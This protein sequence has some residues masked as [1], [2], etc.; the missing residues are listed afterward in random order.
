MRNSFIAILVAAACGGCSGANSSGGGSEAQPRTR[1]EALAKISDENRHNFELWKQQVI[2]ACDATQAFG[3][4]SSPS[5]ESQGVDGVA[6]LQHN[7]NSLVFN[8]GGSFAIISGTRSLSGIA[9]SKVQQSITINGQSQSIAVEAKREGSHCTVFLFGQNV[10]ET[11]IAERAYIGAQWSGQTVPPTT[12]QA[13]Q[14]NLLGS[15]QLAEV[16]QPGLTNLILQTLAMPSEDVQAL[17]TRKLGLQNDQVK[18]FELAPQALHLAVKLS[19]DSNAIWSLPSR[20]IANARVLKAI[21]ST[22]DIALEMRLA[23]PHLEF[24]GASNTADV[25]SLKYALNLTLS[26]KDGLYSYTMRSLAAQGLVPFNDNEATSC[27]RDRA[28]AYLGRARSQYQISPSVD[29]MFAPCQVLAEDFMA[30]A[31][32]TGLL[33]SLIPLVFAGVT[34]SPRA[35]YNQ[36]DQILR[37]LAQATLKSGRDPRAELDPNGQ[38]QIVGVLADYISQLQ[39]ELDHTTYISHLSSVGDLAYTWSFMGQQVSVGR[40]QTILQSLDSASELFIYSTQ[41]VLRSLA[42]NPASSDEALSFAATNINDAYKNEARKALAVAQALSYDDFEN[43]TLSHVIQNRTSLDDLKQWSTQ[44]SAVQTALR[45][46]KN[47]RAV[48]NILVGASVRWLQTGQTKTQDLSAIYGALDNVSVPFTD[49]AKTLLQA[50]TTSLA[51]GQASL[52]FAQS[53]TSEYKQ[54]AIEI[55][56]DAKALDHDQWGQTFFNM[57]LQNRPTT[58]KVRAWHEF[59]SA[60]QAFTARETARTQGEF[61]STTDWNRKSVIEKGLSEI[62]SKTEFVDFETI[63]ALARFKNTCDRFN[64]ASSLADCAGM[65]L[66][67]KSIGQLLDP[68][69]NR[70]YVT[71]AQDFVTA[72]NLLSSFEW[73]TLR[74]D[75]INAYFGSFNP[76]WSKCDAATF[77]NK[78]T[79]LRGQFNTLAHESNQFKKWD[80]EHQIKDSLND[81]R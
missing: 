4:G 22:Q 77:A 64:G 69:F 78:A 6:L 35:Q 62:W 56:D 80:I 25:G 43:R 24:A 20:L 63:A 67:S 52:D 46:Y 13:P 41:E 15:S 42:Q 81:C 76:M 27:A 58:E 72:M 57:I 19:D 59:W 50:L 71:L 61:G 31:N 14:I 51:N 73:T 36:W 9:N 32:K 68:A 49:S 5:I 45:P 17:L 33:K 54:L 53:V 2:K 18:Y 48:Q 10:Y 60:A 47:L 75:L 70:R 11:E 12:L 3:L 37:D 8:Q 55:R 23:P 79:A 66:F 30:T 40:M 16:S 39:N 34:P 38:T 26:Q 1:D 74:W 44:L 21:G 7:G 29:D 65:R 28:L